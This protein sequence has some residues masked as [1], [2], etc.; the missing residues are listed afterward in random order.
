MTATVIPFTTR[1]AWLAERAADITSTEVAALYGLSPYTTH[2]ELWH[3]KRDRV[4][5]E[6]PQ[7]NRILWGTRL[8]DAIAAGIA[9]DQG[10]QVRRMTEY[11]RDGEDRIGASFDFEVACKERGRGL[12]EI[13]NVDLFVFLDDWIDNAAGIEG[14]QHIE[15]Q[16]QH[17]MEVADLPWCALGALVGGNDLKL[18]IRERDRVIGQ[19]IRR[20]TR[21]FWESIAAGTPPKPDYDLDAEFLQRL[22]GRA[23][24]GETIT[25]DEELAG[26]L[27]LYVQLGEAEGQKEALKARIFERTTASKILTTFGS[28]STGTVAAS[29]NRRAFRQL[30][31]TPT[32]T[33]P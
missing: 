25:A 1:D 22:H 17:Q 33:K 27:A 4:V 7:D 23:N 24:K 19:D 6:L 13:K 30:R 8:Q 9:Q 26:W 5:E 15:L 12:L 32:K 14:P 10:W 31:F 11:M 20:R 29:E 18:S 2:F 3:H 21:A 28:F 16:I